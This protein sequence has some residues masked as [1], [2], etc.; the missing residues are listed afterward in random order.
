MK[1]NIITTLFLIF[2]VFTIFPAS[3]VDKITVH[4]GQKNLSKLK[5]AKPVFIYFTFNGT[6][7]W[8]EPLDQFL[9]NRKARGKFADKDKIRI[10]KEFKQV[11][12]DWVKAP[13]SKWEMKR[14][15]NLSEAKK[16]YIVRINYDKCVSAPL[17]GATGHA[18]VTM[19]PVGNA[20]NIIFVGIMKALTVNWWGGNA[21]PEQQ[22]SKM[23]RGFAT[24]LTDFFRKNSR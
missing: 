19:Y 15:E 24:V 9:K 20:K 2:L 23:G 10:I 7:M 17:A 5:T 11:F 3:D 12:D 14:I 1:R 4:Q 21:L 16:G 18:T 22:F 13:G 8:D 6:K